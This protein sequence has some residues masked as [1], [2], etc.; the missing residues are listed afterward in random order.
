M[1]QAEI[2]EH[3][4][5]RPEGGLIFT[6]STL[7]QKIKDRTKLETQTEANLSALSSKCPWVVTGHDVE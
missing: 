4:K 5:T 2:V 7:S 1:A 6:Q 3:F